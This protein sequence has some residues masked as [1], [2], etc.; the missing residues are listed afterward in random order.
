MDL[1]IDR[2]GRGVGDVIRTRVWYGTHTHIHVWQA[3]SMCGTA[4][5]L[6]AVN[7]S[8]CHPQSP[9]SKTA[10]H[11]RHMD[12]NTVHTHLHVPVCVAEDLPLGVNESFLNV[13]SLS[14]SHLGQEDQTL[15]S[16]MKHQSLNRRVEI[17]SP[18]WQSWRGSRRIILYCNTA[19]KGRRAV[20][21]LCVQAV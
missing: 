15:T 9:K 2:Q 1:N 18:L 17:S 12:T 10:H 5:R 20:W 7:H 13:K 21:A 6:N 16:W 11:L 14:D 8:R 19:Q 4:L 3:L